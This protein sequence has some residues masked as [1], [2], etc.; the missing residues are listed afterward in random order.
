M[1]NKWK[2]GFFVLLGLNLLAVLF[3][4]IML[5]S[6]AN[7]NGKPK[8]SSVKEG[9]YVSFPIHTNKEDL[10]KLINQYLKKE[11]KGNQIDY[12][13]NL[14]DEVE[15]YGIVSFFGEQLNMKLTF[16][17]EALNNGDLILRQ[18]SISIGAIQLP[19]SYVLKFISEN[20][21]LPAGVDIM[22]DKKQI[23]IDMQSLNLK[24][25][26]KV[27]VNTF[28]LKKNDIAFTLLVPLK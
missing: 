22:P 24:S 3:L 9:D 8:V 21:K 6:P 19:V 18:K 4:F 7:E 20:Y 11:A 5:M 2:K 1:K 27:K 16:E 12:Q 28:D 15:F 25:N 17:P 23:Y 26:I 10:N 13:V 14:G